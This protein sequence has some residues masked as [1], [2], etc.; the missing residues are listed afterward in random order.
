MK[1]ILLVL[2]MVLVGISLCSVCSA[3][4]SR[5]ITH[6]FQGY[7]ADTA[8]T[9]SKTIYRITGYATGSNASFGV[10]NTGALGTAIASNVA[11]EG[12]EA[13]S[14]DALPQYNFGDDGLVLDSGSTVKV[15]NCIIVIEYI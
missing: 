15:V 3:A 10:Y 14:G 11:V 2:L 5:T 13:T 4:E 6:K 12:G 8:V 7:S 9:A 1:K